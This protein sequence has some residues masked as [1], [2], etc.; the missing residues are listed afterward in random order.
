MAQA[1]RSLG[2]EPISFPSG[3][4][5]LRLDDSTSCTMA[6]LYALC[7]YPWTLS[8]WLFEHPFERDQVRPNLPNHLWSLYLSRSQGGRSSPRC[9]LDGRRKALNSIWL[10]SGTYIQEFGPATMIELCRLDFG[11][12][13][14]A[15]TLTIEGQAAR[16]LTAFGGSVPRFFHD[17]GKDLL[18]LPISDGT[19][20]LPKSRLENIR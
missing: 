20:K 18:G 11:A 13:S 16:Q 17:L 3:K 5:H 14:S 10:R 2:Q 4:L 8:L 9:L 12:T 6:Y 7:N 15:I 19:P 1:L